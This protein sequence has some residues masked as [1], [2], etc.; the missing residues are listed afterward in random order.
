MCGRC[1]K[2]ITVAVK[3]LDDILRSESGSDGLS[4]G[5]SSIDPDTF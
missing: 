4:G 1:W 5:R 2:F 3:V